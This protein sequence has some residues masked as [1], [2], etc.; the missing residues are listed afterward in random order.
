[1]G[2][3]WALLRSFGTAVK[4]KC[5]V[6]YRSKPRSSGSHIR[7]LCR[8]RGQAA[9][10]FGVARGGFADWLKAQRKCGRKQVRSKFPFDGM[11]TLIGRIVF[12]IASNEKR[13]LCPIFCVNDQALFLGLRLFLGMGCKGRGYFPFPCVST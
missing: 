9:S 10:D 3:R 12:W 1:M 5:P 13:R 11:K 2:V 6:V 4:R 7:K 8:W